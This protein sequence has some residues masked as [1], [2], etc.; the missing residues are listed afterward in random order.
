MEY[1]TNNFSY[2]LLISIKNASGFE[3]SKYFYCGF[4]KNS[5][6]VISHDFWPFLP[7]CLVVPATAEGQQGI[8]WLERGPNTGEADSGAKRMRVSPHTL[9]QGCVHLGSVCSL[10]TRYLVCPYGWGIEPLGHLMVSRRW[11]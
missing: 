4:L 3:I 10:V 8:G 11:N 5:E 1:H 2:V 6:S 9:K 7:L